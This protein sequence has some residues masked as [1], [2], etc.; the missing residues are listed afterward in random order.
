MQEKGLPA[1]DNPKFYIPSYAVAARK[2][3]LKRL[4]KFAAEEYSD[5]ILKLLCDEL[6]LNRKA[7]LDIRRLFTFGDAYLTIPLMHVCED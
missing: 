6:N 4:G 2:K 5:F 3:Y 1:I 7:E